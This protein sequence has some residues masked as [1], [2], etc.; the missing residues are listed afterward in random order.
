MINYVAQFIIH[1]PNPQS[2]IGAKGKNDKLACNCTTVYNIILCLIPN[3]QSL[4][5]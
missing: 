3:P 2:F 5:A 1:I 4:H